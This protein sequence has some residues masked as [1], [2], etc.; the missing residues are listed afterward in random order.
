MSKNITTKTT[1]QNL[2]AQIKK[3]FVK[4]TA[5]N[6]V[7]TAAENAFKS[8]KVDGN[9]VQ[10]FTSADKSGTAAFTFDFPKEIFL[11]QTKTEFVDVFASYPGST[12][13]NLEGK[14]VMVL[15]VKGSDDTC[16]Y[17]FLNMASLV[18][19]Y[20][21][22]VQGKDASTTIEIAGY[23]VEVKVNISKADDN[24]LELKDD[25]LYVPK[26]AVVDISGKADKV[27]K[28]T[29]G[30]FAGLDENGNLADSGKKASD[31]VGAEAGKRL[32]TDEEGTKLDGIAEGATKVEASA[33][34]GN[35]K[36]NGEE[37][38]V[39]TLPETVLHDSDIS[40]YTAEEI[41]ALLADDEG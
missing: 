4:K 34:N 17:S 40:D 30:N 31:F 8:A 29:A 16:T 26:A 11:D 12:N 36:V 13:P 1:I 6:P 28:A 3:D 33:T 24:A 38:T 20:K 14:P 21:A 9:S 2:A 18:D 10:F 22:K 27:T 25:G 19:T 7:K 37:K 15:A 23:E 39:Y 41:A 32:M 5:F 35:I